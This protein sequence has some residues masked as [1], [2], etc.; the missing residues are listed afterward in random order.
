MPPGDAV[1]SLARLEDAVA[2]VAAS[3]A[4]PII[5]GGDHSIA[6]PDVTG[7]A[8]HHGFGRIA[9]LHCDAHAATGDIDAGSL[10]G[11]GTPMRRLIESGA[12]RGDRFLQ[13]GLRGY[14][15][16]LR[17]RAEIADIS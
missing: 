11:H 4:L 15:P 9:V 2:A 6:W 3:G 1:G 8:R 14:W 17:P 5:L 16:A 10:C 12:A 7:V 13:I